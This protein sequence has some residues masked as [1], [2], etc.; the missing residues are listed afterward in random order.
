MTARQSIHFFALF[1]LRITRLPKWATGEVFIGAHAPFTL[2]Q[3][4]TRFA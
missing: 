1:L 3:M 2:L 4:E